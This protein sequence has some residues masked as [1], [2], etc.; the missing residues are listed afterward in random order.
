MHLHGQCKL[1]QQARPEAL[2]Q[3][4]KRLQPT[5]HNARCS[6]MEQRNSCLVSRQCQ[7]QAILFD[8]SHGHKGSL[9]RSGFYPNS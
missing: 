1:L 5:R 8:C 6:C 9:H 4:V 3:I 2:L 7:K